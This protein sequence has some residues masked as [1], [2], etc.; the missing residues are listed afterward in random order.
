MLRALLVA[1]PLSLSPI[2]AT[3]PAAASAAAA[4]AAQDG[5]GKRKCDDAPAKKRKK[6]MFG[7]I[8]GNVAGNV[9]GRGLGGVGS[10]LPTSELLSEAIT[11]LLDCKEQQ[12]AAKATDE[13][14]R[15]GVGTTSSWESESRPGVSGA[16]TVT[17]ANQQA[18]G[19]HCMTVTD[20]V[21]IDGEE[22][23]VPKTMCRKPGQSRYARV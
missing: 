13:A 4:S 20:V 22:T 18:D 3:A 17:A 14:V 9:I 5:E 6:S 23:T 16:S 19:S 7:N 10:F 8:M 2:A 12:Q 1:V 15:G 21:I 11:A